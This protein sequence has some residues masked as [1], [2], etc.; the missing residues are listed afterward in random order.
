M[1]EL[2]GLVYS[3][4]TEKARF[5][6]DTR[7][8][9]YTFRHYQPLIGEP[10]LRLKLRRLGG[11]VTVP[12]LTLDDGRVLGDSA[13]IARWA[14]DHGEGPRLFPAE[15][16]AAIAGF[17]ALSER[18]LAAGRALSLRRMLAD[19]EALLEMLPRPIRK[20]G[21]VAARIGSMGLSRTLRKYGGDRDEPAAHRRRLTSALDELR[22]ALARAPAPADEAPRTLLGALTFADIAMAQAIISVEPPA[23]GLKLGAASRR[24]FCDPELRAP[25]ADLVAWRDALYGAY[26]KPTR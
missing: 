11:R 20:L 22:A 2:L 9:P 26:R 13:D 8:V 4:W 23:A 18:A 16:E 6:L 10:A 7:R 1:T 3:P 14:D 21:P 19:E 17:V 24:S 15:H 12:V 5:A 25:Y